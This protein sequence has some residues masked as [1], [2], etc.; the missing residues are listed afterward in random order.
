[1]NMIILGF[2]Y[3]F[4][5]LISIGLLMNDLKF[6]GAVLLLTVFIQSCITCVKIHKDIKEKNDL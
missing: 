5:M 6:C 4:F 1:M 3:I 2:K